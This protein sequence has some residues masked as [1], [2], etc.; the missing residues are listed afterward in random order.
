MKRKNE[1]RGGVSLCFW[2]FTASLSDWEGSEAVRHRLISK[3]LYTAFAHL[4]PQFRER[5]QW[6]RPRYFYFRDSSWVGWLDHQFVVQFVQRYNLSPQQPMEVQTDQSAYCWKDVDRMPKWMSLVR[7]S[8]TFCAWRNW[9]TKIHLFW[10]VDW[11]EIWGNKSKATVL[12]SK[13]LF[14]K[15]AAKTARKYWA[16]GL[17]GL[18]QFDPCLRIILSTRARI[19]L[20]GTAALTWL[21]IRKDVLRR[22]FVVQR[23][24]ATKNNSRV[25]PMWQLPRTH[26][27]IKDRPRPHALSRG[28]CYPMQTSLHA[29]L[30]LPTT[31]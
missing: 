30:N 28:Q 17:K 13:T 1:A 5:D 9:S 19:F 20:N 3:Q 25:M 27:S 26:P 31:P 11:D 16:G 4:L 23:Q 29:F 21:T 10:Y 14:Q 8:F 7:I 12:R 2:V 6:Q 18:N 15:F 22:P 24:R